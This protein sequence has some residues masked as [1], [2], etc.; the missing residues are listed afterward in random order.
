MFDSSSKKDENPPGFNNLMPSQINQNLKLMHKN[1]YALI[2][3]LNSVD[4]LAPGLSEEQTESNRIEEETF[5]IE[6]YFMSPDRT[7]DN[8]ENYEEYDSSLTYL[9][10]KFN[11]LK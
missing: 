9:Y 8:P 2:E 5:I 10:P 6:E 4:Y 7:G 11:T 1:I 3:W